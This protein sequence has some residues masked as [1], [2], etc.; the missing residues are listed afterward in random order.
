MSVHEATS[1]TTSRGQRFLDK[2]ER[3]GNML[4]H[5]FWLFW[6]LAG[7][8]AVVSFALHVAG[9]TVTKPDGDTVPIQNLLSP[10]GFRY[11]ITESI[12]NFMSFPP[13]GTALVALM[14]LALADRAGLLTTAVRGALT[15][16]SPKMVTPV[17]AFTASVAHVAGD[18]GYII[19]IP[20]GGII[21]RAVGRS[22]I[23]GT[24]VALVA[25]S[26]GSAASPIMIPN[27]VILSGITTK[28]AHI[29][30]PGYT[31]T[32]VGNIYFT[33]VSSLVLTAVITLVVDKWLSK[34][35]ER[36]EDIHE[37]TDEERASMTLSPIEHRGL[38]N[39][40][41]TALVY[42]LLLGASMAWPTSPMRG[43]HGGFV[44]S[45]LISGIAVFLALFFVATGTAY[46]VTVN[47]I[48]NSA[49][50]PDLIADG[51]KDITPILVLFFAVS[52]F[53]GYFSWTNI[54][55][56]IATNGAEN[57]RD[58]NAPTVVIFGGILIV[59]SAMNLVITSGSAQWSL[60]GPI[61][62]PMLMLL[63][64]DPVTT[65][66]L[67]RIADSCTNVLTPV[68]PYFAMS[69]AIIARYRKSAGIGTLFSMTLPLAVAMLIAW[70][71]L[72]ALWYL[73]GLPLGP[74][75]PIR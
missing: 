68:S 10:E 32:P 14:G 17:L 71:A 8:L 20:L 50:I 3:A 55:V 73:L 27:D 44:D 2:I 57:L 28:A 23:V 31:M 52:Q 47:K 58:L 34:R 35:I 64:V 26:G 25:L 48:T 24:V 43:E 61:F 66:A 30:D 12:D 39:A 51:L 74:G 53:L 72:F 6:I 9:I 5:P 62:V 70:V 22:P 21:F 7:V 45:T 33:I 75:A 13:L 4:P 18:A 56:L 69:V 42:L 36:I 63:H 37:L 54:G 46:G 60:V 29:V 67:Y 40:G 11:A 38:R 65:T 49:S 59:I 41:I 19:L 1:V 16:V 15:R